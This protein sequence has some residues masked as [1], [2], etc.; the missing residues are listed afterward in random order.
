MRETVGSLK[1]YFILVGILGGLGSLVRLGTAVEVGNLNGGGI[2]VF[3]LAMAVIQ[4]VLALGY[5]YMG[6][7]L[8]TLLSQKPHLPM[9]IAGAAIILSALTFN[10][11]GVLINVYIWYQLKRLATES[12]GQVEQQVLR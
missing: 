6:F 12:D 3:L 4:G 8:P 5:L 10:I 1:A 9:R 11:I 7:Q 2:L